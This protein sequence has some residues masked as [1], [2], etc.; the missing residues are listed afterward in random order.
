MNLLYETLEWGRKWFA[1]FNA[2]KTH[3]V[4]FGR[5]NNTG[6]IDVKIDGSVLE[7]SSFKM[8]GLAFSSELDWGSYITCI[9]KTA[10]KE[11]VAFIVL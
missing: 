2:G 6:V 7:K 3:L 1:D 9:A 8:L 4:S 5:S 10:S 11:I